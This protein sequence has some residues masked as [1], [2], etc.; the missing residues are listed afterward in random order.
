MV[1]LYLG[2][3]ILA[4][5]SRDIGTVIMATA[6]PL[7]EENKFKVKLK[8]SAGFFFPETVTLFQ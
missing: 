7:S 5:F 3:G 1:G 8:L 6:P 4:P 2:I